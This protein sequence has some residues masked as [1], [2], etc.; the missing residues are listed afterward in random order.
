MEMTVFLVERPV[1]LKL[2]FSRKHHKE[3]VHRA[4]GPGQPQVGV[5]I[6]FHELSAIKDFEQG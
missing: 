5:W 2:T 4:E 6:L 1:K 3:G